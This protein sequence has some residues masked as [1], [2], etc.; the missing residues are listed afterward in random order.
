MHTIAF[1]V[2]FLM[3]DNFTYDDEADDPKDIKRKK[4]AF[5]EQVANARTHLDGLK[6]KY[7]SEINA[8][9]KLTPDQK[10]KNAWCRKTKNRKQNQHLYP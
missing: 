9:V 4:L 3:E 1:E 8:G 7:Y 5:K 6:S 2:D 10:R